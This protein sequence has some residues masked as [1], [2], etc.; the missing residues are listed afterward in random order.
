MRLVLEYLLNEEAGAPEEPRLV[1]NDF[2]NALCAL[3]RPTRRQQ[4][5]EMVK[6]ASILYQQIK[7]ASV[8][9][10]E[11]R[12]IPELEELGSISM[13]HYISVLTSHGAT[14]EAAQLLANFSNL[15]K[16]FSL[17]KT[18][19]FSDLH[20]KVLQAFVKD[21]NPAAKEYME[22]L[23]AIGFK[24]LPEFHEALTT[25]YASLGKDSEEELRQCFEKPCVNEQ[26]GRPGA[27]LA[28]VKYSDTTGTQPKWLIKALQTL[29]DLNPPKAWW[30]VILQWAIYQG[31]D[32]NQIKHM[33]NVITEMNQKDKSVRADISTINGLIAAA[34]D[35]KSMLLAERLYALASELGLR[36]NTQTKTLLLQARIAGNDS[37]GAASAFEE[38]LHYSP[39]V[40]GSETE[41]VINQYL[42]YLCSGTTG[43]NGILNVLSRIEK[44][45]GELDPDTVV[46]VC[47]NFLTNDRA[48]EVIDTLGLH[49]K[50]FSSEERHIVQASLQEY[51]LDKEVSTARAW[52]C[53]SLL[54]QFFPEMNRKERVQLMQGF[55]GRKRA[56]MATQIFGHMRGHANEDARPD[57][58][59]YVRCFEGL[60]A[61]PDE[62]ES[63]KLVHNM[64]KT[65]T[66]I[67]PNT[68]LYNAL[69]LAYTADERPKKAFTFFQKI[70]NSTEGPS[71]AS[72]EIVFRACQIM[73]D[74]YEKAKSIWDKMKRLEIEVPIEV[75]DA[76]V[77]MMA[78]Q[79]RLDDL[80]SLLVTRQA[81]Y[82]SSIT[83][84][85]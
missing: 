67:Q 11:L 73:P 3:T 52:K 17:D 72:L 56:D 28:L 85:L 66:K 42:K 65:D 21:R 81:E 15:A 46:A 18:S 64:L 59:A 50:Q 68:R 14:Q 71:Y 37:I 23:E 60:G 31:K 13:E 8:G 6:L 35:H 69:M 41:A 12:S 25:F 30:D 54:R 24:Y 77:L 83:P 19:R 2:R 53:Y 16:Y 62:E 82:V 7:N 61:Y 39:L 32:I 55:F 1:V 45:G 38:I 70:T 22:K 75:F 29:C 43:V 26:M 47:S 40:P 10:T 49:L 48:E 76:Y 57:L 78:G 33:I 20:L 9:T 63:L 58:E 44:Q 5:N 36:P 74:G 34:L 80:K 27:Y 84:V 79:G 51:C 4:G